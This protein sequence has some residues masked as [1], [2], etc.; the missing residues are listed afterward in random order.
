MNRRAVGTHYE[1]LAIEYLKEKGYQILEHNYRN[2]LGE[3]DVIAMDKDTLVAVEVK[4]R[5]SLEF[6]NAL[7]AVNY[8]KQRRISRTFLLY[9]SSHGFLEN[10][11]CRFDVIGIN[12]QGEIIHIENAFE[13][14]Y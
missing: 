4:Y 10:V 5:G 7:E 6:G 13:F 11:S 1:E 2:R 8:Q 9:Y 3:L 12:K 14:V